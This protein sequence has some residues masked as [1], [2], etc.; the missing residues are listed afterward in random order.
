VIAICTGVPVATLVTRGAPAPASRGDHP[1]QK[2][3]STGRQEEGEIHRVC[4][5]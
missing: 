5:V 4:Q 3:E 1:I 2:R